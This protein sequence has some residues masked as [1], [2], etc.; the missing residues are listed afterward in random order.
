MR[1]R[2][3]EPFQQ[4]T[5]GRIAFTGTISYMRQ[6][7]LF[8][9]QLTLIAWLR[10]ANGMPRNSTRASRLCRELVFGLLVALPLLG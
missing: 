6:L 9:F 5:D 1:G 8:A 2:V 7:L 4:K 10:S 3:C